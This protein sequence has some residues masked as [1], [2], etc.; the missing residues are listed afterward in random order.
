[1][2]LASV[3]KGWSAV[4]C[5]VGKPLFKQLLMGLGE[6]TSE[7]MVLYSNGMECCVAFWTVKGKGS[8]KEAVLVGL[9]R[10]S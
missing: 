4:L 7:G 6:W 9:R 5:W 3:V 8:N 10:C 1:M 2:P